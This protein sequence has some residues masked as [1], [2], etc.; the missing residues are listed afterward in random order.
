[1][2]IAHRLLGGT[3]VLLLLVPS[4]LAQEKPAGPVLE[5]PGTPLKVQIV[6]TE[7][8][9]ERKISSL[10]YALNL[11]GYDNRRDAQAYP[12]RLRMG[13]RVPIQTG[14]EG[15]MQYMDVG[16]NVDFWAQKMSDGRFRLNVSVQRSTTYVPE[17]QSKS[18]ATGAEIPAA[19]G[20]N[21]VIGQFS[22]EINVLIQD[23][24]TIQ[25]VVSTDPVSG[26]TLRVDVTLNVVK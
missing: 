7:T 5:T 13:L 22:S 16:T 1:V 11:T 21:P 17:G 14:K 6:F 20:A 26:R 25:S 10:P 8:Q 23:G 2:R 18:M 12:A 3:A 24:Q 9:G 19:G 15:Q 4:L